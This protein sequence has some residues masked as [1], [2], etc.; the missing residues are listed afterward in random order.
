MEPKE[1]TASK[2]LTVIL[3]KEL[4][5]EA[6]LDAVRRGETWNQYVAEAVRLRLHQPPVEIAVA[7]S[8]FTV[9]DMRKAVAEVEQLGTVIPPRPEPSEG[10]LVAAKTEDTPS[11][12]SFSDVDE[13]LTVLGVLPTPEPPCPP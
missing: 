10:N 5:R 8:G 13:V 2:S 3:E 1:P 9:L 7:V 12:D 6:K 11:K 4:H